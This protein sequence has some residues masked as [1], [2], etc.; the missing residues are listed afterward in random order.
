MNN[1]YLDFITFYPNCFHF[2][3]F[4]VG[5]VNSGVQSLKCFP[6]RNELNSTD[7]RRELDRNTP[8]LT[9]VRFSLQQVPGAIPLNRDGKVVACAF[10]DVQTSE[11][12][13][14]VRSQ[15]KIEYE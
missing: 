3:G 9:P 6:Q 8:T 12:V 14:S 15:I 4:A 11:T 13:N 1:C 2:V 7:I 5:F 10:C